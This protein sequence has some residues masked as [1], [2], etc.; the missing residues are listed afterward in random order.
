MSNSEQEQEQHEAINVKLDF[1]IDK[2]EKVEAALHGNG[3]TGLVTL[4][5]RNTQ[6]LSVFKKILWLFA[7]AI[8]TLAGGIV[9][10]AML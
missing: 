6:S 9:L 7:S 10:A 2:L 5:D 3:K 4:V 1:I 8:L